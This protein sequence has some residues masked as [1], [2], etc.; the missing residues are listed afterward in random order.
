MTT[1]EFLA[2]PDQEA[3]ARARACARNGRMALPMANTVVMG[4]ATYDRLQRLWVVLVT[5]SAGFNG[6]TMSSILATARF[7]QSDAQLIDDMLKVFVSKDMD[8][9][10]LSFEYWP[11][12]SL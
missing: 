4:A 5:T 12:Y 6:A 8:E 3:V 9:G 10:V 2:L 11:E 7:S 1:H